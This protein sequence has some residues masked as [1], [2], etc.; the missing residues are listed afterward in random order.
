[1]KRKQ[2]IFLYIMSLACFT[3]SCSDRII[4]PGSGQK[5]DNGSI[6]LRLETMTAAQTKTQLKGSYSLHH[7]QQIYAVLYKGKGDA[8]TYVS[9]QDLPWEPMK[10]VDYG[11]GLSQK[12]EF[13]LKIPT[14]ITAE[15]YTVLCVGLDDQSAD[16]Y[17][18][19][20]SSESSFCQEGKTLA[21]AK[22]VLAAGG[23]MR[24]SELFAGWETFVYSYDAVNTVNVEMRRRVAGAYAYLKDIPV[25]ANGKEVKAVRMVLGNLPPT[26][27]SLLRKT[28]AGS[29][30]PGDFGDGSPQG[31]DAKILDIV[32]LEEIASAGPDGLYEIAPQYTSAMEIAPN[33]ILLS[34]FL[35]PMKAGSEAT[36]RIELLGRTETREDELLKSFTAL[37]NNVPSEAGDSR[38]YSI[39]PNY[40]Y[41]VGTLAEGDDRPASMAGER[42][43]IDVQEWTERIVIT[44]FPDVPVDASLDNDKNPSKYIYDCINTIDTLR[45]FPSLMKNDWELTIISGDADGNPV[46]GTD[47]DWLYFIMPDGSYKQKYKSTDWPGGKGRDTT[48]VI[49]F[50]M[51]DF[52]V[53]RD[54]SKFLSLEEKFDFINNDTRQ[55]CFVLQTEESSRQLH[56]SVSQY[57]AITVNV[58]FD[59]YSVERWHDCGFRRFDFCSR[60]NSDGDVIDTDETRWGYPGAWGY[61]ESLWTQIFTADGTAHEARYNGKRTYNAFRRGD[62]WGNEN[63]P[64]KDQA[65]P[66]AR[67]AKEDAFEYKIGDN[68]N[69]SNVVET[70]FWYLA[71]Q[72]E[73]STFFKEFAVYQPYIKTNVLVGKWYWSATPRLE[74][75]RSYGQELVS[76]G[77]LLDGGGPDVEKIRAEDWKGKYPIWG[78]GRQARNFRTE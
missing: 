19:K 37:W 76:E 26:E 75:Y 22:A 23:S 34:A 53:Q 29:S 11:D 77:V 17:G 58:H 8:A 7:V 27:I 44:D 74:K 63:E 43:L 42:L 30:I 54:Y 55:A 50:R 67:Y 69:G 66:I 72:Y 32:N 59:A 61:W 5:H 49:P 48:V 68:N 33:T 78:Y 73:L 20:T 21:Q 40:I 31:E 57:N 9:H 56:W 25:T 52:V 12:R 24:E 65:T 38:N 41:H 60:R 46:P 62:A 64:N 1:M 39:Y 71:S 10:D 35:L 14:G 15:T 16:T 6:V 51:N 13:T 28:G 36:L 18:L 2:M 3:L 70:E 47:C 45:V 4:E